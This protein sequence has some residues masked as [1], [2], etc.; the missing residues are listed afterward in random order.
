MLVDGFLEKVLL[1]VGEDAK[2]K[3]TRRKSARKSHNTASD[4]H[5][6]ARSSAD[7]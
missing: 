6:V 5:A 1:R 3:V 2:R 4:M 7:K